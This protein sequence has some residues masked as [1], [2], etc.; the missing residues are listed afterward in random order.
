MNA[1]GLRHRLPTAD[2]MA[3]YR[4]AKDH[5][6]HDSSAA[7]ERPKESDMTQTAIYRAFT[8]HC[9]C[10]VRLYDASVR[11]DDTCVVAEVLAICEDCSANLHAA[12]LE[13][14]LD[15]VESDLG[16]KAEEDGFD[17]RVRDELRDILED[18]LREADV[19]VQSDLDDKIADYLRDEDYVTDSALSD[20][21]DDYLKES[22]L[23]SQVH[24]VLGDAFDAIREEIAAGT[25]ASVAEAWVLLGSMS[26]RQRLAWLLL[27]RLP[28]AAR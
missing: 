7:D 28:K 15:C 26:M 2:E 21:L 16:D 27:G 13:A 20:T 18:E 17:R 25:R 23:E 5:M 10:T 1:D 19:V 9:S 14:R 12:R 8:D 3:A 4:A 24:D 6:G 11:L 22:D